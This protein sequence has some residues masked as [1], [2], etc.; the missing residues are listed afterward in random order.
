[1]SGHI[2]IRWVHCVSHASESTDSD[3]HVRLFV[4]PAEM[5]ATIALPS[6]LRLSS[7]RSRRRQ[8]SRGSTLE[9]RTN[10]KPRCAHVFASALQSRGAMMSSPSAFSITGNF[11]TIPGPPN[12]VGAIGVKRRVPSCQR[13]FATALGIRKPEMK[14]GSRG[15]EAT[16]RAQLA[17]RGSRLE[18]GARRSRRR[19]S[20]LDDTLIYKL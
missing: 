5:A 16:Q 1:M 20:K 10:A 14:G 19:L 17:G 12:R 3:A 11:S 18:G 2:Q 8:A 4:R 9:L 6:L 13:D 15:R 7:L